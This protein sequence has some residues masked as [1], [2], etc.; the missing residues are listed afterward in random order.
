MELGIQL[1]IQGLLELLHPTLH[2]GLVHCY[3]H[4]ILENTYHLMEQDTMLS[5]QQVEL[6]L[7]T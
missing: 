4:I 5:K 1:K 3:I 2:F 7:I 6:T